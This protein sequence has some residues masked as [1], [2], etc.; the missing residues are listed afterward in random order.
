[1]LRLK[2]RQLRKRLSLRKEEKLYNKGRLPLVYLAL[3]FA[4]LVID[5]CILRLV[6]MKIYLYSVL[7]WLFLQAI[8]FAQAA[9]QIKQTI[10]VPTTGHLF[11]DND[12]GS[13]EVLGWDK[14]EILVTG[15]LGNESQKVLFKNKDE[16]T[17]IKI[18]MDGSSDRGTAHSSDGNELKVFVPKNIQIHFK[19]IDTDYSITGMKAGVEGNT[20]NGELLISNVHTSIKVSSIS[21]DIKVI[22]SSGI[23]YVETVQGDASIIGTFEDVKVRSVTGNIWTDITAIDK[24]S[25]DNVG[26]D[27]TVLGHLKKDAQVKMTSVQGDLIFQASGKLNAECQIASQFGGEIVNNLTTDLPKRSHIQ[28]QQLNF[29]SGDGSGTLLIQTVNGTISIEQA[30]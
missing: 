29:V 28:H 8:P 21:G 23:A 6:L 1:M 25:T 2:I 19:G 22:E 30:Q 27:T 9:E 4:F 15:E 11:I 16:K 3:K 24:L 10:K 20:I 13:V 7:L 12:L 14:S 26:G 5:G 18:K 17:L